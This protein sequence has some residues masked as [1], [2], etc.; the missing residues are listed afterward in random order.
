MNRTGN[1]VIELDLKLI[2]R[3]GTVLREIFNFKNF[4]I[5]KFLFLLLSYLNVFFLNN[6]CCAYI[7]KSFYFSKKKSLAE[8]LSV[9]RQLIRNRMV[10]FYSSFE[11]DNI[12][13]KVNLN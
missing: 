4:Y 2:R 9:I 3:T 6:K 10:N 7:S 8:R 11:S 12:I 5:G 13:L 1:L